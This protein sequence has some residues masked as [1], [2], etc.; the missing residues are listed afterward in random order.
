MKR[1]IH[2]KK[3]QKITSQNRSYIRYFFLVQLSTFSST[4]F[5]TFLVHS[6]QFLPF[7]I[8]YSFSITIPRSCILFKPSS[9][10]LVHSDI[11][12]TTTTIKYKPFPTSHPIYWTE[13]FLVFCCPEYSPPW[14]TTAPWYQKMPGICRVALKLNERCTVAGTS[15]LWQ[16]ERCC[17]KAQE[18]GGCV[19]GSVAS[20]ELRERCLREGICK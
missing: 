9:T 4:P 13:C 8:C 14:D 5:S 12:S 20:V 2:E 11:A 19:W 10:I 15:S 7:S 18:M 1:L 17:E 16:V 3:K 6:V